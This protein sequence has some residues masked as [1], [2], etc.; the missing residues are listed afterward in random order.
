MSPPV[1]DITAMVA[2]IRS[3]LQDYADGRE[4]DGA[5]KAARAERLLVSSTVEHG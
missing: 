2:L 4:H 3:A 1:L 5:T